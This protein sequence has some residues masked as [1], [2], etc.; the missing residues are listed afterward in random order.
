MVIRRN[1]DDSDK[2]S[3]ERRCVGLT[4]QLNESDLTRTMVIRRNEDEMTQPEEDRPERLDAQG[5]G[6]RTFIRPTVMNEDQLT[7]TIQIRRDEIDL[8]KSMLIRRNE[9]ED[10]DWAFQT[11]LQNTR[12][13]T[14]KTI[15]NEEDL[16]RTIQIRRDLEKSMVIR[17]DEG[18]YLNR[19]EEPEMLRSGNA[20]KFYMTKSISIR[21]NDDIAIKTSQQGV[22]GGIENKEVE[23][24]MLNERRN[25]DINKKSVTFV[26]AENIQKL[27]PGF[28][29]KSNIKG[30]QKIENREGDHDIDS[31]PEPELEEKKDDGEDIPNSG[32][33]PDQ[34][35]SHRS[36]EERGLKSFSYKYTS[37]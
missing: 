5:L 31:E 34:E 19:R 21:R 26:E 15:M 14:P 12:E 4:T 3:E 18:E 27:G 17:R 37:D 23:P 10:I 20:D 2:T 32:R 1:E 13:I 16:T 33:Q 28:E 35:D 30:S 7:R 11:F 25:E 9:S 6:M 36:N 29:V 22:Q 8:E 24:E